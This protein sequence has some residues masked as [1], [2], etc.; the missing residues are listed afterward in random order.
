MTN[1]D[2]RVERRLTLKRKQRL[3]VVAGLLGVLIVSGAAVGQE[4][5]A[6]QIAKF[7]K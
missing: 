2:Q 3:S 5:S 7:D 1:D 4:M 6:E